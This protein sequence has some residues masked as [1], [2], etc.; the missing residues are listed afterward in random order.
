M[1][2]RLRAEF[3]PV[4]RERIFKVRDQINDHVASCEQCTKAINTPHDVL[5]NVLPSRRLFCEEGRRLINE[6][7][8]FYG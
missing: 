6:M 4:L 1:R 5:Q 2:V 8:Q 7:G 3:D